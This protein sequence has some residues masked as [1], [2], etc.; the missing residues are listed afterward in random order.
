M[1]P[2]AL[3]TAVRRGAA[4]RPQWPWVALVVGAWSGLVALGAVAHAPGLWALM[5]VAMMVPATLPVLRTIGFESMWHRRYRS[6]ALFLGAYL[7]LGLAFGAA[8]IGAFELARLVGAGHAIHGAA[9]AGAILVLAANWQLAPTH[10]RCLK[11]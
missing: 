11:R 9:A 1:A 3:P 10:R 6:P 8:A 2:L 4:R 7:A 5:V